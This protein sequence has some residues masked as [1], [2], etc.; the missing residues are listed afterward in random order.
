MAVRRFHATADHNHL[1]RISTG[2]PPSAVKRRLIEEFVVD[3]LAPADVLRALDVHDVIQYRRDNAKSR[4]QL[5]EWI[6]RLAA[7]IYAN[8]WTDEFQRHVRALA[9]DIRALAADTGRFKNAVRKGGAQLLIGAGPAAAGYGSVLM[10]VVKGSNVAIALG[11]GTLAAGGAGY[12]FLRELIAERP[13]E[14]NAVSY[15]LGPKA[16]KRR[17]EPWTGLPIN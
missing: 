3:Q 8:E 17:L 14:R 13:P 4:R 2:Q 12:T 9:A 5:A 11:I 10:D 7:D 6:D 1:G 15:L 16:R